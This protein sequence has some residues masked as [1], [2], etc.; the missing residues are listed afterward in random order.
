M[1]VAVLGC[2]T[3]R[4]PA[5]ALP[6]SARPPAVETCRELAPL[7]S[8]VCSAAGGGPAL[9]VRGTVLAPDRVFVGGEIL[10]SPEGTLLAV[11]C[12]T[13]EAA[14]G[15]DL[16]VVEC[17]RGVISPGLINSH[18]HITYNQN[19]PGDWGSERFDHRQQW[20]LGLDGHTKIPAPRAPNDL[21]VAWSEL[22]QAMSG[23]TSVLGGGGFRG[24]LRNL[25]APSSRKRWAL[26]RSITAPSRWA[27]RTGR[28][29]PPVVTIPG[30]TTP[31]S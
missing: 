8:G 29:R 17:P 14:E 16:T 19:P 27:T 18:D 2:A 25:D 5:P 7:S 9:L 31:L 13:Q 15:L 3:G 1:C 22:R 12:D 4:G 28:C 23:T 11:G 30:S 20:R 24:F 21:Q 26:R 6:A 10:I